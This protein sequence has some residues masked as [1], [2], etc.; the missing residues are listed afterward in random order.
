MGHVTPTP[1][2]AAGLR[3]WGR[4]G[5]PVTPPHHCAHTQSLLL[6]DR[7]HIRT[8]NRPDQ[9]PP[10]HMPTIREVEKC[11]GSC[12]A[13]LFW[14]VVGMAAA[15]YPRKAAVLGF[16]GVGALVP[17]A[18]PVPYLPCS[19]LLGPVGVVALGLA[20]C[21]WSIGPDF[22]CLPN[23][24]GV[25]GGWEGGWEPA[26]LTGRLCAFHF[27][28]GLPPCEYRVLFSCTRVSRVAH[29]TVLGWWGCQAA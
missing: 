4:T 21:M 25:G 12:W 27:C 11:S 29:W 13:L 17:D 15:P 16:R 7:P 1:H 3:C 26:C 20:V 2:P 22:T 5:H 6:A 24:C 23:S 14:A 9:Q 8:Q 28:Q 18:E 10:R 19:A